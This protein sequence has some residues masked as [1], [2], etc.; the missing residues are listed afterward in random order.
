MG[1]LSVTKPVV[2]MHWCHHQKVIQWISS[3]IDQ[4]A[5]LWGKTPQSFCWLCHI[6]YYDAYRDT[7]HIPRNPLMWTLLST[8]LF[9]VLLQCVEKW[10]EH[11]GIFF[12]CS[13]KWKGR[14]SLYHKLLMC[15]FCSC[16]NECFEILLTL[17]LFFF[18]IVCF[19]TFITE[20]SSVFWY[21]VLY[22]EGSIY[23]WQQLCQILTNSNIFSLL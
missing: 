17:F 18:V 10:P 20:S 21:T 4:P 15:M 2:S 16:M 12:G 13:P 8:F 9:A 1:A 14:C 22:I 11:L 23:F 7:N 19:I 6:T 3:C 5:G